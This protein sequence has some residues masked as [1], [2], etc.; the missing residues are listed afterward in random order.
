M[1]SEIPPDEIKLTVEKPKEQKDPVEQISSA[2]VKFVNEIDTNKLP[3]VVDSIVSPFQKP[4]R[5]NRREI[6]LAMVG[7]MLVMIGILGWLTFT[8]T[9][10]ANYLVFFLTTIGGFVM[11]FLAKYFIKD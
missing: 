6:L 4:A 7:I 10:D 5:Q 11:G 3:K 9:V 1:V 2:I 8:K